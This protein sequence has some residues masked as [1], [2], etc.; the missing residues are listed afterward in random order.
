[1]RA[2][3]WHGHG[4]VRVD[5]VPDPKI[6]H[7]R[8]AIIKISACAICGSDLHL[9]SGSQPTMK[10]GEILGHENMRDQNNHLGSPICP[11]TNKPHER[12]SSGLGFAVRKTGRCSRNHECH[13]SFIYHSAK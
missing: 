6:Q 8:D 3:C 5:T 4:D 10:S 7:P 13:H 11:G 12:R 2:L 1:M 9:Y